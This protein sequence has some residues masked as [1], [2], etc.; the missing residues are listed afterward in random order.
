MLP[1]AAPKRVMIAGFEIDLA[2]AELRTA[3]APM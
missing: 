2:R 1:I 3:Q